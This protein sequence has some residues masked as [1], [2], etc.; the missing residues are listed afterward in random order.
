MTNLL[1][2]EELYVF[3]P[4]PL[5]F[6]VPNANIHFNQIKYEP[7]RNHRHAH[8]P[9]RP[10]N[11]NHAKNQSHLGTCSPRPDR[12]KRNHKRTSHPSPNCILGIIVTLRMLAIENLGDGRRLPQINKIAL[13]R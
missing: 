10:Q 6:N 9:L 8:P 3:P 12:I 4:P 5:A 13:Y 1:A 11:H 2:R 7:P